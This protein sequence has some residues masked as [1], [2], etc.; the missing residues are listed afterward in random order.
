MV[1]G[2]G[3]G[4]RGQH[5]LLEAGVDALGLVGATAL[6]AGLGAQQVA[7][8]G[9]AAH[10]FAGAGHLE[11]LGDGLAG[12]LHGGKGSEQRLSRTTCKGERAGP[13]RFPGD[14]LPAP[15]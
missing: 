5:L 1:F 8:V 3:E 15:V 6:L 10:D 7:G 9:G 13:P 12:L 2:L 4:H 14:L 11:A